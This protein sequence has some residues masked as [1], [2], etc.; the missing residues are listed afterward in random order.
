MLSGRMMTGPLW[1]PLLSEQ[2]DE[3]DDEHDGTTMMMSHGDEM[4]IPS[5]SLSF[6]RK[7]KTKHSCCDGELPKATGGSIGDL[8]CWYGL[9]TFSFQLIMIKYHCWTSKKGRGVSRWLAC[10]YV[11]HQIRII[12]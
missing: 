12:S 6:P 11:Y 1:M 9:C 10:T 7:V 4:I 3:Y 2:H 5:L 8:W